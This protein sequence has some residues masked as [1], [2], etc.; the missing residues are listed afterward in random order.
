MSPFALTITAALSSGSEAAAIDPPP[1][2]ALPHDHGRHDCDARAKH[3][4]VRT[5]PAG[6]RGWSALP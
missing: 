2:L 3:T 4:R 6:A 1:R 5:R